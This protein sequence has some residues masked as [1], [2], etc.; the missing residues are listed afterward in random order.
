MV[1]Y[2]ILIQYDDKDKIYVASIPELPGCMAHGRTREKAIEE[3]ETA[4]ELWIE[5]AKEVGKPI[6]EPTYYNSV[7]V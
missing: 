5:T 4:C 7:M 3:L 2:S 6:P 1:K